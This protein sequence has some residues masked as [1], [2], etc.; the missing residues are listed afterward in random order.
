MN[1]F[2][3][4]N[5]KAPAGIGT[6]GASSPSAVIEL[7]P[8]EE[9]TFSEEWTTTDMYVHW[10]ECECGNKSDIALHE[11][12]YVMD[13]EPTEDKSGYKHNECTICGHKKSQIE[14]PPLNN[15]NNNNNNE[16]VEPSAP[17]AGGIIGFFQMIWN[18]ILNFFKSIFG[19]R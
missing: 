12:E 8:D 10:H 17:Q 14:I 15:N 7:L 4:L 9:C 1:G 11:L 19:L 16:P 6:T 3:E 13:L 18:A 2:L 5:E